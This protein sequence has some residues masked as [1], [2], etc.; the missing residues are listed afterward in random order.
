M[1]YVQR[2]GNNGKQTWLEEE[3]QEDLLWS[4]LIKKILHS[5]KSKFQKVELADS[6]PFG[7]IL[8]L[9]GKAQSA[10]ADEYVYHELLV[11]P[12]MLL[13]PNP[14]TVF[15]AGGG[16]GSTVREV[17]KHRSVEKV[18]MVDIDEVVTSFCGAHLKANRGAFADPR[19]ELIH[20]DARAQ[21]EQAPGKFDVI[22]GDLADPVEGGPCYQLYT[23]EFYETVIKEKLNPGGVFVTQSGPA[24]V[25]SSSE[26]F[27]PIHHTLKQVFP[28][29]VP[30][31]QHVPSFADCWGWNV[32]TSDASMAWPEASSIDQ[33]ISERIDGDL[34][35]LDGKTLL[36]LQGLNKPVRAS[37]ERETHVLSIDKPRFIHGSGLK[38]GTSS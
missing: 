14:K 26:V 11:H 20:D 7:K 23:Q 31:A 28:K 30:Y 38:G 13:H 32:A 35:F 22:I 1:A 18:V 4:I 37:L 15:V 16:E 6:G 10:E 8:L 2:D 9:D 12:A 21:L 34:Q 25:L 5:G 24:G 27:A 3:L 19:L 29:V 36:A 33:L 17:L